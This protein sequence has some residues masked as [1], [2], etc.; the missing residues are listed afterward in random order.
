M[1]NKEKSGT[2]GRKINNQVHKILIVDDSEFNREMLS[3]ILENDYLIMQAE[4]GMRALEI[5]KQ[6]RQE[7]SCVLLDITMPIKDG[8]EVLSE[9]NKN[10]WINSLPVIIISAEDSSDFLK[11]SYNLGATDYI[12]RPF[13]ADV[14]RHRVRNTIILYANQKKLANM[15]VQQFYENERNSSMMVAILGHI[16]EFR[17][18][19]SGTHIQNVSTLTQILLETLIQKTNRYSISKKDIT[20]ISRASSMHDIGKIS[21]P[22]EILNKPG[23]LTKSEREEIKKHTTIGAS[24][25]EAIPFYKEEPIVKAA[26]Q[27]CRWHHERFDGQGYPDGIQGDSIPIAAQ[28]VA[29]ADVYDALT[30]KRCY[31]DAYSHEK[32]I[33]MINHNEC[34]VFNPLLIECLNSIAPSLSEMLSLANITRPQFNVS[35]LQEMMQMPDIMN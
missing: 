26:Y 9:M 7:F 19:E 2:V 11:K 35:S 15:V 3:D 32:A 27:I 6:R 12:Q 23:L 10:R 17:N 20:I 30:S 31:K 18:K 29:L 33:D 21:I 24:M 13:D 22:S 16:V 5:L 25:I 34:G 28:V 8:F 14:V 1:D 4:N